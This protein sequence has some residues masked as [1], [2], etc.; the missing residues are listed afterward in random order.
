M[1]QI[2]D[3]HTHSTHTHSTRY[4]VGSDQIV[5]VTVTDVDISLGQMI[6]LILKFMVACIP[7]AMILGS[8]VFVI[9]VVMAVSFK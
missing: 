3:Q 8:I 6:L 5:R 9:M 4:K 2:D 1:T 7:A